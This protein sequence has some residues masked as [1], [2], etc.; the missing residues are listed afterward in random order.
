MRTKSL[1]EGII[2]LVSTGGRLFAVTKSSGHS[3]GFIR[4]PYAFRRTKGANRSSTDFNRGV[5]IE[6]WLG[7]LPYEDCPYTANLSVYILFVELLDEESL[8]WSGRPGIEKGHDK[9]QNR[10]RQK[11]QSNQLDNLVHL[12][13][14]EFISALRK[15][16]TKASP[17]YLD[18]TKNM[19]SL[20]I[21]WNCGWIYH[22]FRV[23]S[24]YW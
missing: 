19:L 13:S 14:R 7:D 18:N 22:Q 11:K 24:S 12:S 4:A 3:C 17:I 6:F 5:R 21:N 1:L 8:S 2:K 20:F 16:S 10:Q 9:N 23:K 15:Q